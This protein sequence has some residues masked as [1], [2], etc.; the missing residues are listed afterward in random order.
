[1]AAPATTAASLTGRLG[2]S[3]YGADGSS[4]MAFGYLKLVGNTGAPVR[5]ASTDA[6]RM[7]W[8]E[9]AGFSFAA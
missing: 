2:C 7:G 3:H 4:G 5:G 1:M 6:G 9:V 8:T